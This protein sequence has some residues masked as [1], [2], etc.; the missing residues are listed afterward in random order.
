VAN[1]Q[2]YLLDRSGN[3]VPVGVPGELYIGGDGLA[4][5]YWNRPELTA[6]R[7]LP[8][9]WSGKSG[10][11]LYKTGDLARYLPDGNLEFLGRVDQ[12]V[13]LRGFRIELGEVEAALGRH[14]AVRQAVVLAR[15]DAPGHKRL[16]AYLVTS[17]A[18]A[19]GV[20]ELRAFLKDQ[21]PEY[22]VPSA[23]VLLDALPRTVNG[24]IDRGAL[25]APGPNDLPQAEAFVAPRTPVEERLAGIWAEVLSLER[26]GVEDDFFALGGHS[27]LAT[28][29][30][31]WVRSAFQVDLPLR[32]LFEAPTVAGLALVIAQ[33]LAE[34][35]AEDEMSRLLAELDGLS[36]DR[37]QV[38]LHQEGP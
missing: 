11:R 28:R 37:A 14:P 15:E 24:K 5:G 18:Q 34:K 9:P 3:P 16:V 19:P 20:H 27:L 7:F 25:P 36:E 30:V 21:L 13:K 4:R 8:D 33:G 2:V 10:A 38:L 1:T 6:E 17:A 32:R 12:Q 23:F 22:M 35:A 29:V 31:S 26:V